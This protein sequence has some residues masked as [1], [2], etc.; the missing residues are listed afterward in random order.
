MQN[1]LA[2]SDESGDRQR[3]RVAMIAVSVK[4]Q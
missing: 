2:G 1:D 3:G 4:K